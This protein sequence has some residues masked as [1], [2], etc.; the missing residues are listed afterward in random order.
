MRPV[1]NPKSA[2]AAASKGN[3][4]SN[5]LLSGSNN[6]NNNSV[7]DFPPLGAIPTNSPLGASLLPPGTFRTKTNNLRSI[8]GYWHES[9]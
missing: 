7:R 4:S 8:D 5:Y 6:A 3:S 9:I 2:A 1:A